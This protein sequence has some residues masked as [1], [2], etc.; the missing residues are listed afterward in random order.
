MI[1][2]FTAGLISVNISVTDLNNAK[3]GQPV[4]IIT[5]FNYQ[6]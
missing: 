2:D 6:Q 5:Y 4:T 3:S 1:I